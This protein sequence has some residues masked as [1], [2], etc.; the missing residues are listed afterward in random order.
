MDTKPFYSSKT[1]WAAVVVAAAPVITA[2]FPPA[3][4]WLSAN[5]DFVCTGIAAVFG[6]LR[7]VS[8]KKIG[9]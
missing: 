6:A 2:A 5:S 8:D 7:F 1:F 3:G 4:A 9:A